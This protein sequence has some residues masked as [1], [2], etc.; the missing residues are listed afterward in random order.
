MVGD[1]IYTGVSYLLNAYYFAMIFYIIAS[2]IPALRENALG[3][4]VEKLVDPY[5]SI[6]RKVIPPLGMIDL[7]PIVAF[8]AFRFLSGF[9]LQGVS[10]VLNAVGF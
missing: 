3:R 4:F 7:S 10:V 5:L 9:L 2:W 1:Y 8:L 6:F